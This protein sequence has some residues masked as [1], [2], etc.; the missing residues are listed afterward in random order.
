MFRL[1]SVMP[2]YGTSP[3]SALTTGPPPEY[4]RRGVTILRVSTNGADQRLPQRTCVG[5]RKARPK[6]ELIRLVATEAGR[7]VTLDA[8]GR[9]PGRGAYLCKDTCSECFGR[10]ERRRAV[11]RSLRVGH[12]VI[13]DSALG[14]QLRRLNQET[15]P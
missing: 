5:C 14:D 4:R 15:P 6:A 9:L 10:A 11:S 3:S 2:A 8:S 7:R 13:E 1:G 12:D